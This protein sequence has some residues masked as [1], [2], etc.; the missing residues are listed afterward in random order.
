MIEHWTP[1]GENDWFEST[2]CNVV[3]YLEQNTLPL[4]ACEVVA[5]DNSY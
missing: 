3:V 2:S 5:E 4:L 1:V